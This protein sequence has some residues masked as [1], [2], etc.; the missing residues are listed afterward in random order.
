MKI[1]NKIASY[2]LSKHLSNASGNVSEEKQPSADIKSVRNGSQDTIVHLSDA[3]KEVKL[4]E[5]IIAD[6]PAVRADKV[7]EIRN[8]IQSGTYEID[9]EKVAAKMIDNNLEELI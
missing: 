2:E 8:Q 3:S 9:H 1:D 4:A 7:A 5:D 6:T